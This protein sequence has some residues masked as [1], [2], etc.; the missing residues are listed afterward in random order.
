MYQ[1]IITVKETKESTE[2]IVLQLHSIRL[3]FSERSK[4]FEKWNSSIS[5]Q[6]LA[7]RNK[8]EET[9][10]LANGVYINSSS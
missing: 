3:L 8:I 2:K 5:E 6:L 4:Y 7:L 10:H 9:K 1:L